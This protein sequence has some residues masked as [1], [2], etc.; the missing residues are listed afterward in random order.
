M[1][2]PYRR[3]FSEYEALK[4]G[5]L[6]IGADNGRPIRINPDGSIEATRFIDTTDNL[7]LY[8][9]KGEVKARFGIDYSTEAEVSLSGGGTLF[10]SMRGMVYFL[11]NSFFVYGFRLSRWSTTMQRRFAHLSR[12]M[13][14]SVANVMANGG[15]FV[16]SFEKDSKNWGRV[17]QHSSFCKPY[18]NA[19]YLRATDA[20][21]ECNDIIVIKTGRFRSG[22]GGVRSGI[23]NETIVWVSPHEELAFTGFTQTSGQHHHSGSAGLSRFSGAAGPGSWFTGQDDARSLPWTGYSGWIDTTV[24]SK[25]S[26][27]SSKNYIIPSGTVL[28]G[29]VTVEKYNASG[30]ISS[31]T[32]PA[33]LVDTDFYNTYATTG[34]GADTHTGQ[35]KVRMWT[36]NAWNGVIP[37]DTPY[38]I[39]VWAANGELVGFH[40]QIEAVPTGMREF[41]GDTDDFEITISGSGEGVSFS[42]PAEAQNIAGALAMVDCYRKLDNLLILAGHRTSGANMTKF[43]KFMTKVMTGVI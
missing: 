9:D 24:R 1:A 10:R 42:S 4:E 27:L 20:I 35:S 13:R 11:R 34:W 40:G 19:I 36:G 16:F 18:K 33:N 17:T 15:N 25:V 29:G 43:H 41:G 6:D 12:P 38:K 31:E 22:P 32:A 37:Q 23:S 2:H 5:A 26:Y 39:E 14:T 21:R 3:K 7:E 8:V 30:T 28:K